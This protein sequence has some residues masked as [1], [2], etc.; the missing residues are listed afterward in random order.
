M[1]IHDIYREYRIGSQAFV[2]AIQTH[3]GLEASPTEIERIAQVAPTPER[4]MQV[5]EDD[6]DWNDAKHQ[7]VHLNSTDSEI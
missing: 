2:S 5:W 4:F 1:N 6:D 7:A 3:C